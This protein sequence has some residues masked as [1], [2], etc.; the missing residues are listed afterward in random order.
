MQYVQGK[1]RKRYIWI[2]IL[3]GTKYLNQGGY[4]LFTVLRLLHNEM[5]EGLVIIIVGGGGVGG[6]L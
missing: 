2:K 1:I 6:F 5:I 4:Q 3:K